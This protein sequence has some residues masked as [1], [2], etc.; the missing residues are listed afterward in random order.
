MFSRL[1][2]GIWT[3]LFWSSSLVSTDT[4]WVSG[5]NW[6]SQLGSCSARAAMRSTMREPVPP[7]PTNR[8]GMIVPCPLRNSSVITFSL[9]VPDLEEKRPKIIAMDH[10]RADRRLPG[11]ELVPLTVEG[12]PPER[13][14]VH[15]PDAHLAAVGAQSRQRAAGLPGQLKVAD[16]GHG[17]AV[18]ATARSAGT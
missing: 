10:S 2:G 7:M 13:G 4:K 9:P 14:A 1:P 5:R 15:G 12:L 16:V 6:L 3:S 11:I 18:E 8:V 17:V